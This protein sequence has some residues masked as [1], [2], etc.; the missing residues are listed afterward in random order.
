MKLITSKSFYSRPGQDFYLAGKIKVRPEMEIKSLPFPDQEF[1]IYGIFNA[2]GQCFYIGQTSDPFH[3]YQQHKARMQFETFRFVIFRW[4][5][6]EQRFLIE[7]RVT[8][9]IRRRR[10]A[11]GN[12][13]S[14]PVKAAF[15]CFNAMKRGERAVF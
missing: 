1:C 11:W 4:A 12:T 9:A 8:R 13:S 7:A 5:K 15:Y 3:R 10:Q 14:H 2:T 6:S